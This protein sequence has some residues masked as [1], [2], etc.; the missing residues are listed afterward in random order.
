MPREVGGRENWERGVRSV[1]RVGGGGLEVE[2]GGE[3]AAS[4]G[5]QAK[6]SPDM[7][8]RPV[9]VVV[10]SFTPLS[11]WKPVGRQASIVAVGAGWGC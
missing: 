4:Q 9:M 8:R 1:G 5:R 10:P 6:A 2:E 11:R 3:G 7:R